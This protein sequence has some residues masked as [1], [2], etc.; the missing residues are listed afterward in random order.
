MRG[1]LGKRIWAISKSNNKK[2]FYRQIRNSLLYGLANSQTFGP[3]TAFPIQCLCVV[4]RGGK[5][6]LDPT[7][8]MHSF[9]K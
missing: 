2:V 6:D 7:F 5:Y 8:P 9:Y 4:S 3:I 1:E